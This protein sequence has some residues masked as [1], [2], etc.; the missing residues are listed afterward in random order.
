[1]KSKPYFFR[2]IGLGKPLSLL[3]LAVSLLAG[4]ASTNPPQK[5]EPSVAIQATAP[6]EI[7]VT[8]YAR[9]TLVEVGATASQKDL[10]AQVIDVTIPITAKQIATVQDAMTYVLRNSGYQLCSDE[11][12]ATFRGFQLPIA[13][14]HLGPI[15]V[16]DA[17]SILAGPAWSLQV[18]HQNRMVC[19]T[20]IDKAQEVQP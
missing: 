5:T 2:F 10:L 13:H 17:L 11:A 6:Q 16:K 4:C 3:T 20:L 15:T 1:M 8:R 12:I 19:F 7:P 14:Q 9:Y 18:D